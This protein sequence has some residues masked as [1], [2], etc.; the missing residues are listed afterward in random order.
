MLK[1]HS[2]TVCQY[3]IVLGLKLVFIRRFYL[4][5]NHILC[6]PNAPLKWKPSVACK[7]RISILL[8][9]PRALLTP[10][11]SSLRVKIISYLPA[12]VIYHFF[13]IQFWLHPFQLQERK[14]KLTGKLWKFKLKSKTK[15]YDVFPTKPATAPAF[16]VSCITWARF[17][18]L[19]WH[20]FF[21]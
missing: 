18:N 7:W 3:K 20:T 15:L 13:N 4:D 16:F 8:R 2:M 21:L 1:E 19:L 6:T 17:W 5:A 12:S 9:S 11:P 14:N 10:L